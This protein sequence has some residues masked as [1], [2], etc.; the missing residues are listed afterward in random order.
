MTS[1]A[2]IGGNGMHGGVTRHGTAGQHGGEWNRAG[3]D[4]NMQVMVLSNKV[5]LVP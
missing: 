5:T 3:V 1:V 2:L 4:K